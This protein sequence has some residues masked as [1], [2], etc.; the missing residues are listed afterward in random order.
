MSI[1]VNS[2]FARQAIFL[3]QQ[4][5]CSER[6]VAGLLHTIMSENPN[7]DPM[8]CLEMTVAAFHQRRRHLAESLRDIFEAAE[9]S[10][11]G[12]APMLYTRIHAFVRQELLVHQDAS[13]E[14]TLAHRILQEVDNLE[15]LIA[16]VQTAKQNAGSLS[17][18]QGILYYLIFSPS[19]DL[20][21]T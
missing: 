7:V 17:V 8:N 6:Y 11:V 9:A 21:L 10:T 15:N 19:C 1:A 4:L 14:M 13:R 2:E 20:K 16:K 18:N 12:D 5:D 3:S